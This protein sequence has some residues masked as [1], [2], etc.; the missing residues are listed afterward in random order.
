[1]IQR[2]TGGEG[3]TYN[4][5]EIGSVA[6]VGYC[7]RARRPRITRSLKNFIRFISVPLKGA[8]MDI[9]I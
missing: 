9:W 1:M 2:E 8:M 4:Q 5:K 6:G 7:M 3:L